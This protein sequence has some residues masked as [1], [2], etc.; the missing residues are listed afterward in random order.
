M[1]LTSTQR[2]TNTPGLNN[3]VMPHYLYPTALHTTLPK[4][5]Y[6][7]LSNKIR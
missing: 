1:E 6:I 2:D 5:I 7:M 4:D 3:K